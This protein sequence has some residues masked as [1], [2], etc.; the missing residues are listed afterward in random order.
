LRVKEFRVK[1]FRV[2][3]KCEFGSATFK[4]E[5]IKLKRHLKKV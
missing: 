3:E 2:K 4:P 5:E 1:E